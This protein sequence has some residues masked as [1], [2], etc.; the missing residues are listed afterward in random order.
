M[1]QFTVNKVRNVSENH[2][3]IGRC[4]DA[5]QNE[6]ALKLGRSDGTG[7]GQGFPGLGLS[8]TPPFQDP[9]LGL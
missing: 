2:V 8:K 3:V 9:H 4:R 6:L 1:R 7:Y 5:W